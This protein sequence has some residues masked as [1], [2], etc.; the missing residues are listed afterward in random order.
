MSNDKDLQWRP[1]DFTSAVVRA[2]ER[3]EHYV[4]EVTGEA[5]S[6]ELVPVAKLSP[7]VYIERPDYWEID[8]YERGDS[9]FLEKDHF[10]LSLSLDRCRGIKG[11]RVVGR[12]SSKQIDVP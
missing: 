4:L 10:D 12:R 5:K 1:C 3:P 9:P 7:R 6:S 11:I 2:D 8:V